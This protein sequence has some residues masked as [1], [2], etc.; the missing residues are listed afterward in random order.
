MAWSQEQQIE[1]LLRLPWTIVVA[2]TPEGDPLLRIAEIPSAVGTGST[3]EEMEADLWDALR[4]ALSAYLHFGD[5]IPSPAGR[6]PGWLESSQEMRPPVPIL[7][8]KD[9]LVPEVELTASAGS[10]EAVP[11]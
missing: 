11:A 1:H 6:R 5:P 4:E 3:A 10:W 2:T 8:R 9:A 7:V